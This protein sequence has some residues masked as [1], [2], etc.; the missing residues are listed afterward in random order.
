VSLCEPSSEGPLAV[1]GGGGP[2]AAGP[3]RDIFLN[4]AYRG[5]T[6]GWC[7]EAGGRG[8]RN[9]CSPRGKELP[10]FQRVPRSRDK[11][12]ALWGG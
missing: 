4:A 5:R 6:R 12:V 2:E 10:F 11:V 9:P 7:Q 3:E 1:L 8:G